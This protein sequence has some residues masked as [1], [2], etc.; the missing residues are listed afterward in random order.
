MTKTL[1]LNILIDNQILINLKSLKEI[2]EMILI[3]PENIP[4]KSFNINKILQD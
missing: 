2:M 3:T 1:V 4:K